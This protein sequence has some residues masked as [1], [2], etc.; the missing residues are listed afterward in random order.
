M[1]PESPVERLAER[2]GV[3]PRFSDD[4]RTH[5]A[6]KRRGRFR[7]LKIA[8]PILFVGK[9]EFRIASQTQN[10]VLPDR[11]HVECAQGQATQ[12][13]VTSQGD[14]L[15]HVP[16]GALSHDVVAAEEPA[17]FA[18]RQLDRVRHV[19][20]DSAPPV[21]AVV[22]QPWEAGLKAAHNLRGVIGRGSVQND[23]LHVVCRLPQD[24]LQR[25]SNESAEVICGHT[26]GE[27]DGG[28]R[29]LLSIAQN[30][31]I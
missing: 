26:D 11:L 20:I 24:T 2:N 28:H 16:E 19:P 15:Q 9:V 8:Q 13:Q 1:R 3:P 4:Q 21:A 12:V 5:E 22:M 18:V 29:I 7:Q 23:D 30:F 31:S 17:V 27:A 25:I 6:E 10:A 14:F